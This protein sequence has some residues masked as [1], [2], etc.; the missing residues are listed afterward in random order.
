METSGVAVYGVQLPGRV[1]GQSV[2]RLTN[3]E[4]IVTQLEAQLT[5]NANEWNFGSLPLVILGHSYGALISYEL[6]K[7]VNQTAGSS[8][9]VDSL[10]ISAARFPGL[11]AA[12]NM[13]STSTL[14]H[15]TTD[16]EL[17]DHVLDLGGNQL[18]S[19]F[20]RIHS[21]SL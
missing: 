2:L 10:I 14:H 12:Y 20:S 17:Y 11:V 19:L 18:F 4:E 6:T 5:K 7:L 8:L 16:T 21:F 1:G 9:H 13:D 15:K 3:T